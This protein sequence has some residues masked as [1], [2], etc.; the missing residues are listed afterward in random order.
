MTALR[1]DSVAKR[2]PAPR[3]RKR[4]RPGSKT[5]AVPL[6]TDERAELVE[7]R[8]RVHVLETEREILKNAAAFFASEADRTR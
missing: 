8:R 3:A 7:L 2:K 4:E 1:D 5:K 6:P